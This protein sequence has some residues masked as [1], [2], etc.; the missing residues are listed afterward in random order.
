MS[1]IKGIY[2]ASMSVLNEDLTLN[3]AKTIEHAE[4]VI[5]K[6]SLKENIKRFSQT[7]NTPPMDPLVTDRF[8][9]DA[10]NES[11][12]GILGG[13]EP[14]EDLE[15][16]YLRMVLEA[17]RRPEIISKEGRL[18]GHISLEEHISAWKK[19]KRRT[20][21]ERSQLTFNN[22][23]AAVFNKKMAL[24]DLNL[25]QIPY[26]QG[27]APDPNKN[28]TDFQIL[29][30]AQVFEV[31]KM[32]TIQL[33]PAAFNM[34]N[35]KTGRE[36]MANVESFNLLPNEQAGSRK[37]HRAILTAL[38]KVLCIDLIRA[39][40]IP[41][42]IIFNDAKSC[43]D[44][45]VLWIA[46][47]ALRRLGATK[48]STLEMTRT[49]QAASHKICTAYGDST[50]KYGGHCNY[51]PLQGVGQGNGAGPAIWVAISAVLLTIMRVK[52]F[53]FSVLSAI[54]LKAL[55][56]AGFAFVDDTNIIHAADNPYTNSLDVLEKAQSAITTWEGILG[57]TGGAIGA[58]D[59]NKAFWYFLD[60]QFKRG[61]WKYMDK[62][63]FLG[64]GEGG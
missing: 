1:L 38:S 12:E 26:K 21:S 51:P 28:F 39:R 34:N 27:F 55:V 48:E 23:K 62:N 3:I 46:A 32:R 19:Q 42:I 14:L 16:A 44:R 45:I 11:A 52:G 25:R 35:K 6:A 2:A 18:S 56:L 40:K 33:M 17:M 4:M 7:F 53:G 57:A 59:G 61:R 43:Y 13:N 50:S 63:I 41:T 5:E 8:G 64:K 22:F 54:S 60:F 30:K 10:D 47:L 31:E 29:K 49:L 37:N 24:T 58:E 36:V 9:F 15:D 20:S